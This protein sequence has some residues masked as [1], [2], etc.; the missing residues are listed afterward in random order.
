MD[1]AKDP[2]EYDLSPLDTFDPF[3]DADAEEREIEYIPEP[4]M[5]SED[6]EESPFL[7]PSGEGATIKPVPPDTRSPHERTADLFEKMNPFRKTLLAILEYC[8]EPQKAESVVEMVDALTQA[9]RSV[10]A[11]AALCAQL[12][13]AGAL[14]RQGQTEDAEPEL[15]VE[16]GVEYLQPAQAKVVLW[17]T[18]HVGRE[19]LESYHP[20][21]GLKALLETDA[22]YARFYLDVLLAC[23]KEGGATARELGEL[24]DHDPLLANP[25]LY[26]AYF[27]GNLSDYDAV[28]WTGSSWTTTDLGF[29]AIGWLKE[30]CESRQG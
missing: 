15:I 11:P 26:A 9:N 5:P 14:E 12:E 22:F 8:L 18:T 25:R 6:D 7:P 21:T 24:V 10:Y 29:T 3:A 23:A 4:D 16:D 30:T 2:F 13:R 1:I 20:A 28:E 19:V 17:A 27:F